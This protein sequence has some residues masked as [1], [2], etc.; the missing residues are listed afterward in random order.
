MLADAEFGFRI[1]HLGGQLAWFRYRTDGTAANTTIADGGRSRVTG[2]GQYYLGQ[3]GLQAEYVRSRQA[4]RR[5]AVTDRLAQTSWQATGSW[6][7]TGEAATGRSIQP[8]KA[9]DP[10]K[11]AWG[12]FEI[13]ARVNAL[14]HGP[15]SGLGR[16]QALLRRRRCR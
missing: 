9:F 6:V 1:A 5:A 11:G 10:A 16:L 2:F 8:R 15:R 7:L 3:L 13:V 12:A 14:A 4:V